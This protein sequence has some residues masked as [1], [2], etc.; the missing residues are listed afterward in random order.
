M[1]V[2]VGDATATVIV[3]GWARATR[4]T[5][6]LHK[7]KRRAR[8]GA[9]PVSQGQ[10]PFQRIQSSDRFREFTWWHPATVHPSTSHQETVSCF[11]SP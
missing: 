8:T 6:L 10:V 2:D 11:C 3:S 4:L 7:S 9:S 1:M 5:F